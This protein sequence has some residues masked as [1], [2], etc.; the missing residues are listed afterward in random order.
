MIRIA[1]LH[2]NT[3]ENSDTVRCFLCIVI[4]ISICY[5]IVMLFAVRS[6]SELENITK[7]G[8]ET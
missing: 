5:V 2:S 3:N 4:S 7:N 8:V 6:V 1:K